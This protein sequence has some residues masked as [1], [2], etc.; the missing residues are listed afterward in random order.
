MGYQEKTQATTFNKTF[1]SD[2]FEKGLI[3]SIYK[4]LKKLNTD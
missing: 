2:A 4:V 3:Y 1:V